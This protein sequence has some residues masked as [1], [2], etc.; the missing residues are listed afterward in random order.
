M[1]K[2]KPK[3]GARRAPETAAPPAL[4]IDPGSLYTTAQ[5]RRLI[6]NKSAVTIWRWGRAGKLGPIVRL[7]DRKHFYGSHII[8]LIEGGLRSKAA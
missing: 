7:N 2:H 3:R 4:A 8:S 1:P 6:G 5:L